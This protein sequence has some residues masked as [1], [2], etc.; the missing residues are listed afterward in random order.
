VDRKLHFV[1]NAI[2]SPKAQLLI[3]QLGIENFIL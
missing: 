1:G 2:K 3:E